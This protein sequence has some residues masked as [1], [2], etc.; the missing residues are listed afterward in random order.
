MSGEGGGMGLTGVGR[1]G[2]HGITAKT[3]IFFTRAVGVRAVRT[4]APVGGCARQYL[5]AKAVDHFSPCAL[6]PSQQ[7]A[8]GTQNPVV[9]VMDKNAV[10]DGVK[11]TRPLI[12]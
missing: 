8:V 1:S 4:S 9:Q 6:E 5:F 7:R 12:A 11:R 10:W 2:N 3:R